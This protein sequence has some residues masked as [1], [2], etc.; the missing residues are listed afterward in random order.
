MII[1]LD[2]DG[3]ETRSMKDAGVWFD[4]DLNLFAES[5]GWLKGDDGFLV[6][7]ENGNGL[8]EDAAEMFGG[9]GRTGTAELRTHDLNAD[10]VINVDDAIWGSLRVW[11]DKDEDAVTDAGELLSLDALGITEFNLTVAALNFQTPQR[12]W[13]LD[14][15]SYTFASG[16]TGLFYDAVFDA[17]TVN[18][19]YRGQTGTAPWLEGVAVDARSYG[20]I[21]DLSVAMSNDLEFGALVKASAASMTVPKLKLLREQS[22]EVLGQ[23]GQVLEQTRELTA[24]RMAEVDGITVLADYGVY[25]EDA[26]G[27]FFTLHSGAAIVDAQ[28]VAI[29][30]ATLEDVLAQSGFTLTQTFSP[31]S[32]GE[33][34]QFRAEVPYLTQI[35]NERVVILDHGVKP[36]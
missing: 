35:V 16:G 13:L 3:I 33:A 5:T 22:A 4:Q 36:S 7:D 32:R 28:G 20:A 14:K 34:T 17:S 24:V 26:T 27:G 15:G 25:N 6:V 19:K 31:S 2:G 21:V 12:N 18:T 11:Q 8:I 29:A 9:R 10:G 23:W 30:R 1:D